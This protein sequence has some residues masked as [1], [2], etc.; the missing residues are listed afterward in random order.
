VTGFCE[1]GNDIFGS[2]KR[3]ALFDWVTVTLWGLRSMELLTDTQYLDTTEATV[4]YATLLYMFCVKDG[5]HSRYE[6]RKLSAVTF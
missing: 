3:E 6:V 5:T 1:H 2:V 4:S